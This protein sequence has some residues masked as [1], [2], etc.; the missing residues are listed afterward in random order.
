MSQEQ[1]NGQEQE[2]GGA[3]KGLRTGKWEKEGKGKGREGEGKEQG[4]RGSR[5]GKGTGREGDG[6]E[7]GKWGGAREGE[8]EGSGYSGQ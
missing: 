3:R 5:E 4:R 2:W 6:S 8:E 1:G 7:T